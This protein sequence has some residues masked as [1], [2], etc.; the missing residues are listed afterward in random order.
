MTDRRGHYDRLEG[1]MV[2]RT[3]EMRDRMRMDE[4]LAALREALQAELTGIKMYH[5][6]ARAIADQA[7]CQGLHTILEVE[8]GHAY[9]LALQIRNLGGEVSL[10]NIT[11]PL[12]CAGPITD[13]AHVAGML[14]RNLAEEQKAIR[15][16]GATIAEF[17]P[18]ADDAVLTLLEEN[19][20]DELR[21][22]RWLRDQLRYWAPA[23]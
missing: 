18:D 15:H 22:A 10:L 7:L 11:E 8:Q 1:V 16:Y 6:H 9:A 19:L 17:L 5:A 3:Q 23:E 14:C 12:P 20:A 4:M 21:H 2:T 13:P